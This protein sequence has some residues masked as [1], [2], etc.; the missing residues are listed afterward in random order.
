V[1]RQNGALELV[2]DFRWDNPER[3]SGRNILREIL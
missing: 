3:S 1:R 2:E